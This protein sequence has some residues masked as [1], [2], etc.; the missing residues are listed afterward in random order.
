MSQETNRIY[1]RLN[2]GRDVQLGDGLVRFDA[3]GYAV[4]IV[5]LGTV[6]PILSEPEP[7]N[8]SQF[9]AADSKPGFAVVPPA[10]VALVDENVAS[11]E[12][13]GEIDETQAPL[14]VDDVPLSDESAKSYAEVQEKGTGDS[15]ETAPPETPKKRVKGTRGG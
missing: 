9:N 13:S 5:R 11:I 7:L 14:V 3:Q 12:E 6:G 10:P 1:S 2:A 8:Q 15:E 4:G